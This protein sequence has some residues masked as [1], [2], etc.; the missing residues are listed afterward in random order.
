M[1]ATA[2]YLDEES[3]YSRE[4]DAS[5][6]VTQLPSSDDTFDD[7]AVSQLTGKVTE[8]DG[9]VAKVET[10]VQIQQD[11]G[12]AAQEA[13]TGDKAHARKPSVGGE[14]DLTQFM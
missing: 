8:L 4:T 11:G 14:T 7:S 5:I 12:A 2:S 1:E 13:T 3:G 6:K 9:R 10:H